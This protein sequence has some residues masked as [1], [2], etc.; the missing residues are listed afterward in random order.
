MTGLFLEAGANPRVL[1]AD[2]FSALESA[3]SDLQNDDSTIQFLKY[4]STQKV[5]YSMRLH[6]YSILHATLSPLH[7]GTHP[8]AAGA[9]Y[10]SVKF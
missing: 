4:W 5:V 3:I 8:D 10:L 2:I 6:S 7:R 1:D 9:S